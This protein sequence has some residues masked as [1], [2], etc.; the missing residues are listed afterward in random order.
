MPH[1]FLYFPDENHW[2]LKPEHAKVWYA[3]VLAFLDSTVH[4][5]PWAAPDILR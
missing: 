5:K 1:K 2:V 4:G 3:T